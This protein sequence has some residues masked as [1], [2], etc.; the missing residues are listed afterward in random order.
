MSEK[1]GLWRGVGNGVIMKSTGTS[2]GVA[3]VV[4]MRFAFTTLTVIPVML[5]SGLFKTRLRRTASH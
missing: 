3:R 1:G 4:F 5:S 2:L